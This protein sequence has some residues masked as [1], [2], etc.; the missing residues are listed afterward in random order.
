[1]LSLGHDDEREEKKEEKVMGE[2]LWDL[3]KN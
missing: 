2:G 3:G 1:M